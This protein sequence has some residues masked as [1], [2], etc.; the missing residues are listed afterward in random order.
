M[1]LAKGEVIKGKEIKSSPSWRPLTTKTF[2]TR[3]LQFASIPPVFAFRP[4]GSLSLSVGH[5]NG[6]DKVS[7]YRERM[8]YIATVFSSLHRGDVKTSENSSSF[9]TLG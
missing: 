7:K 2:L 3:R 5:K 6:S 1:K 8:L 9:V 4:K